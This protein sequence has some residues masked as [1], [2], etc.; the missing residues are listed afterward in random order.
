ML[1][2]FTKISYGGGCVVAQCQQMVDASAFGVAADPSWNCR[3][4][5]QL[6]HVAHD[7]DFLP[8]VWPER[9]GPPHGI[10]DWRVA[11]VDDVRAEMPARC[12]RRPL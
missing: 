10:S 5:R 3:F 11:V 7:K 6:P 9:R 2:A 1:R 8:G 12:C 4:A